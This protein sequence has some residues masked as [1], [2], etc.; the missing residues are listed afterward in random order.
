MGKW[1]I[2]GG[3]LAQLGQKMLGVGRMDVDNKLKKFKLEMEIDP[4]KLSLCLENFIKAH[5]ERLEREGVI[6]GLS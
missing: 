5:M 6:F 3:E 2:E 1:H 4:E